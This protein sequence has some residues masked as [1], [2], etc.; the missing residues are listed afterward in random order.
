VAGRLAP[1]EAIS[2]RRVE[3][4][5]R[6]AEVS[7]S[8]PDHDQLGLLPDAQEERRR[9]ADPDLREFLL[10]A[11]AALGLVVGDET[12]IRRVRHGAEEEDGVAIEDGTRADG[13]VERPGF[14]L[15]PPHDFA[16]EVERGDDGGTEDDIDALPV[17]GRRGRR[18]AASD[19]AAKVVAP[20]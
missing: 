17:G 13:A 2:R 10:P 5:E 3:A 16:F 1:P 19:A 4:L 18:I 12:R 9:M 11:D 8:G 15:L 7:G 6:L 20:P 14:D